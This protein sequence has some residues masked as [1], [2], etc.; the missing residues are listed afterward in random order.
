MQNVLL[1][2]AHQYHPYSEGYL[3][4]ALC[5]RIADYLNHNGYEVRL[6]HVE[7]AYDVDE[8]AQLHLWADTVIVQSPVYWMG[9]PWRFK[10]YLDE[11]LM[12]GVTGLMCDGDGRHEATPKQGYGTG[13]KLTDKQYMFSL[14]LNAP[15]E[16]FNNPQEPFFA[17]HS[18][19]DMFLPYHLCYRFL[20]MQALPTFACFDVKKNPQLESDF[21][22]LNLHLKKFLPSLI[23]A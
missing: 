8:Q 9:T 5:E 6:V 14:T 12:A 19:D 20:G 11:V 21:E 13:G 18:L 22:R 1:L 16:A 2:N 17:G 10:Q 15:Q 7:D 23:S 4:K 3:N